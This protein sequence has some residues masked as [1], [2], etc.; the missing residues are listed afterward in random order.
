MQKRG[1][2]RGGGG[3][4][5]LTRLEENINFISASIYFLS[6]AREII[7]QYS[8]PLLIAVI[9]VISGVDKQRAL[10]PISHNKDPLASSR[11]LWTKVVRYNIGI[12]KSIQ[13]KALYQKVTSPKSRI[14]IR[15]HTYSRR[16]I[17]CLIKSPCP[18]RR[19]SRKALQ[20]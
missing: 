14:T 19:Y 2:D 3:V 8:L 17:R 12:K 20:N 10:Y 1:K 5:I 6:R 11:C 13:G 7:H 18:S 16:S 9:A 15:E 4:K